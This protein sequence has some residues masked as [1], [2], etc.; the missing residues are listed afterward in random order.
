MFN[1][2]LSRRMAIILGSPTPIGFLLGVIALGLLT[3]GLS[4]VIT[5]LFER[6]DWSGG[7]ATAGIG[8]LLLILVLMLFDLPAGLR[9]MFSR[10]AL[11]TSEPVALRRGLV[12]LVSPGP[13]GSPQTREALDYHLGGVEAGPHLEHCWLIS[14]P[15]DGSTALSSFENARALHDEF[16]KQGVTVHLEPLKSSEDPREVYTTVLRVYQQASTQFGLTT[17]EMVADFTAGTKSMTFGMALA[18]ADNGWP[19]QFMRVMRDS[20]LDAQ[21]RAKKGA[22]STPVLVNIDFFANRDRELP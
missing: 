8:A 18:C 11:R 14:G 17:D 10:P 20:D 19:L 13:N 16:E 22:K 21:R 12:A 5:A 1:T 7:G 4:T 6:Q 15:S 2:P 9:R 3:N